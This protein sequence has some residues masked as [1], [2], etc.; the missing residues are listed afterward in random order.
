M[1]NCSQIANLSARGKFAESEYFCP[2]AIRPWIYAGA[3]KMRRDDDYLRELMLE[4]EASDEWL[5]P[6]ALRELR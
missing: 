5:H 3:G 1:G 6:F 4:L 2:P